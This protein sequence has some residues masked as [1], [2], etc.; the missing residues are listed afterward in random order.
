M[1]TAYCIHRCDKAKELVNNNDIDEIL[2][3]V[4]ENNNID[5][6]IYVGIKIKEDKKMIQLNTYLICGYT[7]DQQKYEILDKLQDN[8]LVNKTYDGNSFTLLHLAVYNRDFKMLKYLCNIA[9]ENGENYLEGLDFTTRLMIDENPN[10]EIIDYCINKGICM[11]NLFHYSI[12]WGFRN[13]LDYIML[14][15]HD[16]INVKKYIGGAINT[17]KRFGKNEMVKYLYSKNAHW[18]IQNV[19]G[20]YDNK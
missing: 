12:A 20:K 5:T 18:K 6:R 8:I 10:Y 7:V 17:A 2:K 4:N 16:R 13:V 15:Y 19:L 3:F 9:D 14:N 11:W 1:P